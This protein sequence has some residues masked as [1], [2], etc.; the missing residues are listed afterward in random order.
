MRYHF[1]HSRAVKII[2][3]AEVGGNFDLFPRL[4]CNLPKCTKKWQILAIINA[5][6]GAPTAQNKIEKIID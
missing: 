2:Q 6:A 3:F 4:S 5:V 1:P